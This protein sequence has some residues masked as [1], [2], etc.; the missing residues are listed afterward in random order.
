M[1]ICV[2]T[3]FAV[4]KGAKMQRYI[5]AT[6]SSDLTSDA[7]H[8]DCDSLAAVAICGVPIGNVLI[9]VKFGNDV[10]SYHELLRIWNKE[11]RKVADLHHWPTSI[12]PE[13]V[14]LKS[15]NYWINNI[16]ESCDGLG[17][18][19][20]ANT[21]AL[22]SHECPLCGGDGIKLLV[23]SPS[24]QKKVETMVDRLEELV[25][26][27]TRLSARK[28]GGYSEFPG[29]TDSP[30]RP[31]GESKTIVSTEGRVEYKKA[32]ESILGRIRDIELRQG[33]STI[34][35]KRP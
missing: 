34:R 20:I 14:A 17:F 25:L 4:T 30:N 15:L 29:A 31:L 16:C 2:V 9:R 3:G 22:S 12:K 13:T 6:Q 19:K 23:T 8:H 18:L 10:N 33:P 27:A 32:L 1:K 24:I 28:L 5:H 35:L 11:V 26:T 7:W 21:P